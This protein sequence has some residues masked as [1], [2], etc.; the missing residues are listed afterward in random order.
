MSQDNEVDTEE[1]PPLECMNCEKLGNI[2]QCDK[3][4]EMAKISRLAFAHDV[5]LEYTP[6]IGFS[7][8][9]YVDTVFDKLCDSGDKTVPDK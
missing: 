7:G 6:I 4:A 1:M 2:C 9:R 5:K 8:R 3:L